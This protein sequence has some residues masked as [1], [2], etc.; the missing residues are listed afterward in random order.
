MH[1]GQDDG[2]PDD[3]TL[4]VGGL[5]LV[6]ANEHLAALLSQYGAVERAAVHPNQVGTHRRRL[7]RVEQHVVHCSKP[8]RSSGWCTCRHF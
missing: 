8:F 3:R 4:F 7:C 6:L 5:P 2:L 1:K